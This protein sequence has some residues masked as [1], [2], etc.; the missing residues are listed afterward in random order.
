[1]PVYDRIVIGK[2]RLV[3]PLK[4]NAACRM[5]I[6]IQILSQILRVVPGIQDRII[7]LRFFRIVKPDPCYYVFILSPKFLKID[8][9][10]Y[11]RADFKLSKK[12]GTYI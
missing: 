11:V 3:Q 2:A 7:D 9:N 10:V 8:K 6:A 4:E 1:M 5:L 12:S